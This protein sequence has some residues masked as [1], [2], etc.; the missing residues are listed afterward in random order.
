[1]IAIH[2]WKPALVS[3]TTSSSSFSPKTEQ[4]EVV[5]IKRLCHKTI[6]TIINE[7]IRSNENLRLISVF[8][9]ELMSLHKDEFT[10]KPRMSFI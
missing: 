3:Y 4:I 8:W 5:P 9:L 6:M 2:L 10:I 7:S 1:M